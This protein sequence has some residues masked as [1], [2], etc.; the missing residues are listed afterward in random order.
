MYKVEYTPKAAKSLEKMDRHTARLISSWITKNLHNCH[1]PR[2]HGKA[3]VGNYRG[4]WRY[5]VGDYR[6]I[7]HIME[8]TV[9]ILIINIGHRKDVY[10]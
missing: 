8:D 5:R 9:V 7:A 2:L 6:L 3:L 4:G 1:D 10:N